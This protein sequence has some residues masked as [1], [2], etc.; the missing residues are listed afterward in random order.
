MRI[1]RFAGGEKM[2]FFIGH[3]EA[4]RTDSLEV[5]NEDRKGY[6]RKV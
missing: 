4:R 6:C 5:Y 3:T 2:G 1:T